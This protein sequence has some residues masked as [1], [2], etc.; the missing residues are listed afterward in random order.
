MEASLIKPL[1]QEEVEAIQALLAPDVHPLKKAF[2][3]ANNY[4]P[5]MLMEREYLIQ[6]LLST[7]C[8]QRAMS[9][10]LLHMEVNESLRE[11]N[12][13]LREQL[14][15]YNQHRISDAV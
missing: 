2:F 15:V 13:Q 1:S 3:L 7:Q 9:E 11:D 12:R 8:G 10:F 4:V 6:A 5:R 14:A